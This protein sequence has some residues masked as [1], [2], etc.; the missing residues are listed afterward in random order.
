MLPNKYY[1]YKKKNIQR[2]KIS[3][4]KPEIKPG[5]ILPY[6]LQIKNNHKSNLIISKEINYGRNVFI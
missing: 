1:Q 3:L 6:S 2:I 5:F 4:I